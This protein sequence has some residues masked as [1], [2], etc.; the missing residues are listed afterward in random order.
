LAAAAAEQDF[1]PQAAWPHF[2]AAFAELQSAF[3]AVKP[4]A[5]I[6]NGGATDSSSDAA[7]DA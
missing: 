2:V 4:G 5:G 3:D 1:V 7:S 6:G